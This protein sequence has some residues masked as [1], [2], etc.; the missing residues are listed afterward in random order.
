MSLEGISGN[1]MGGGA[2]D[3]ISGAANGPVPGDDFAANLGLPA[4]AIAMAPPGKGTEQR[5]LDKALMAQDVYETNAAP[6]PGWRVASQ[7]DLAAIGLTPADLT[8]PD[9]NFQARVYVAGS[10]SNTDYVVAFRGTEFTSLSDW[11]NN[12]RQGVGGDSPY[13]DQAIQIGRQTALSGADVEFV[14]HS[15]GGGMASA[16]AVASGYDAS[17]YNAAGLSNNTIDRATAANPNGASGEVTAYYVP[18]EILHNI[19]EDDSSLINGFDWVGK[20]A[21][22]AYGN[23]VALE[24]DKP[25]DVGWWNYGNSVSRHGMNWVL[26]GLRA[27]DQ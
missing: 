1:G 15:L 20:I 23:Q 25:A 22:D 17:T 2:L 10:G 19:Q 8:I 6:P 11:N 16:A 14:G 27:G 9:S 5:E 24:V 13:Y 7:A 21:P 18:G 4:D 12:L 26:S 3:G